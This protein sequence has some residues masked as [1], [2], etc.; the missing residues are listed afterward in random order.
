M[1][2][3]QLGQTRGT[4]LFA[5][6][7]LVL[8]FTGLGCAVYGTLLSRS[9]GLQHAKPWYIACAIVLVLAFVCY[10]FFTGS[11]DQDAREQLSGSSV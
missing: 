4:I 5:C 6:A 11:E 9:H 2:K 3:I 10:K 7:Y 8:L 1:Q